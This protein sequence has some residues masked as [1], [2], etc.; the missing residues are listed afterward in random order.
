MANFEEDAE[1]VILQMDALMNGRSSVKFCQSDL[2]SIRFDLSVVYG[3]PVDRMLD[4]DTF[5]A[6]VCR[7]AMLSPRISYIE[8]A[9]RFCG[10]PVK[11]DSFSEQQFDG[12]F[13]LSLSAIDQNLRETTGIGVIDTYGGER[14]VTF[15]TVFPRLYYRGDRSY[16]IEY[17]DTTGNSAMM[18]FLGGL[19]RYCVALEMK[20]SGLKPPTVSSI[21]TAEMRRIVQRIH[22]SGDVVERWQSP[23]YLEAKCFDES[24]RKGILFILAGGDAVQPGESFF[25]DMRRYSMVENREDTPYVPAYSRMPEYSMMSDAELASYL[26]WRTE[27]GEGRFSTT[28]TGYVWLYLCELINSEEDPEIVYGKISDLFHAYDGSMLRKRDSD[29]FSLDY[30]PLIAHALADYA[31]LKG[32]ELPEDRMFSCT[33]TANDTMLRMIGGEDV[34]IS[35]EAAL[36]FANYPVRLGRNIDGDV[37]DIVR[38]LLRTIESALLPEGIIGQCGIHEIVA[39]VAVFSDIPLETG[40]KECS[41]VYHDFLNSKVFEISYRNMIREVIESVRYYHFTGKVPQKRIRVFGVDIAHMEDIVDGHFASITEEKPVPKVVEKVVLDRKAIASAQKDLQSI[42]ELIGTEQEEV[43]E[44]HET[45][46]EQ[47]V[48]EGW[49]GFAESLTEE[50]HDK[51]MSLMNSEQPIMDVKVEDSINSKAMAALGD[52]VI[53]SGCIVSDYLEELKEALSKH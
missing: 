1:S 28:D 25:D 9:E 4:S 34:Q 33:V 44:Q 7:S 50:E 17:I 43:T 23:K 3:I 48:S 42:S 40:P 36:S 11:D 32:L 53:E 35:K 6:A 27:L 18:E 22:A 37:L 20:A 38:D 47:T 31:L 21:I 13:N 45:K 41:V 52:T 14:L 51:L 12:V 46:F 2:M 26:H 39:K 10:Y 49:T 19:F 24:G 5:R 30:D 29:F 15:I 8:N 16:L